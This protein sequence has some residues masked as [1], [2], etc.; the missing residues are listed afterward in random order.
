MLE[1]NVEHDG[2]EINRSQREIIRVLLVEDNPGDACLVEEMLGEAAASPF[3]LKH[4]E[5]VGQALTSLTA[6]DFQIILLD[7]S[8]PDGHGFGTIERMRKVAANI[9]IVVLT[10]LD[11]ERI[12]IKAL[13]GGAQDYLV[14]G[15]MSSTLLIRSIRYAIERKRSEEELRDERE[16]FR[17]LFDDAPVGYHELDTEGN[18]IRINKTEI[19]ML[20]YSIKEMVNQPVWKFTIDE[21]EVREAFRSK[22]SGILPAGRSFERNYRR[23][24]NSILTVMSGD[25]ILKDKKGEII[26]LRTTI[27]DIMELKQSEKERELL[28]EQLRQLQKMEA[29]GKLAGG[30]AHDF[31]NLL[32]VIKG[33]SELSLNEIKDGLP[34][35]ENL[36]EIKEA[37]ERACGLTRQL[38][39][40]SRRQILEMKVLDL[41]SILQNLDKMLRRIIGEDIELVSLL[42]G[43]LGKVKTDPGQ[44]EQVIVNLAVNARDAMPNGGKLTIETANEILDEAYARSHIAVR[45]GA[46][47]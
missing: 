40:F 4:V 5:S 22:I 15:Q 21:E 28:E 31:N 13:Q 23:K 8:L 14:K 27:Q 26:G 32:T 42:A 2:S 33:Y 20:G 39:A 29:V 1:E 36:K 46:V 25:R 41:N 44:I 12:A 6:E 11:D 3:I 10:G 9:P 47:Y 17:Q 38:L 35:E 37:T 18:I 16:R 45:P 34:L 43:D 30:I 7:L 19:D 24:D